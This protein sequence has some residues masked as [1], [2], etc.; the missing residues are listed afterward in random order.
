MERFKTKLKHTLTKMNNYA[1]VS[2]PYSLLYGIL[3]ITQNLAISTQNIGTLAHCYYLAKLSLDIVTTEYIQ[4]KAMEVLLTIHKRE[5]NTFSVV[6]VDL[7]QHAANVSQDKQ[8]F[9]DIREYID[10]KYFYIN[11]VIDRATYEMSVSKEKA[12]TSDQTP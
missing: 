5:P 8:R 10:K 3:E 4:F 7:D 12:T 1:P 2:Y 6:Q 11:Q 9:Q